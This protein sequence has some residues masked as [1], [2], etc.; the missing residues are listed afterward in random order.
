MRTIVL[1]ILF[2][3][4]FAGRAQIIDAK[5]LFN[6]KVISV[7][8]QTLT[9]KKS[10][11]ATTA[12]DESRVRVFT[13]RFDGFVEILYVTKRYRYLHRGEKLFTI[14]SDEVN[15]LLHEYAYGGS[16]SVPGKLRNLAIPKSEYRKRGSITLY[17]PYEGYVTQKRIYEGG[18]VKKGQS[19]FQIADLSDIWVIAKVYQEDLKSVHKGNAA[20]ISIEG[21]GDFKGKIEFIYPDVDPKSK[22]IDVRIVL[23]NKDL[24]IFPGMFATVT[25]ATARKEALVLPKTAVLTKGKKHFVFLDKGAT[26][27]PREVTARRIDATGF[28]IVSGLKAGE[29]VINRVMFM[30]DSD[31]IT[32][33]LYDSDD[34]EE[35]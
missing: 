34:D 5:Q 33:G 3:L 24:T 23:P 12:V 26:Y 32:N 27:E 4:P 1:T 29:K 22:T 35:W 9:L 11:Y 21:A 14:Y 16:K 15:S 25:V 10:F 8:K 31:A 13:T 6:K 17:A 28:E 19:L 7:Q 20:K 2:L 30:L 18:Y